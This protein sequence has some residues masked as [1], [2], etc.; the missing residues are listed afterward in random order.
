MG[1]TA[2][3]T[4]LPH[5]IRSVPIDPDR[6][7]FLPNDDYEIL[8]G[9]VI[10]R[11]GAEAAVVETCLAMLG[12]PEAQSIPEIREAISTTIRCWAGHPRT[13]EPRRTDTVP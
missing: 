1:S 7:L 3:E 12:D 4:V 8:A 6:A 13:R 2:A 5:I 11:Q 9:R 10:R